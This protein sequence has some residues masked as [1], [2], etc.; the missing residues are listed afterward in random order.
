MG[1]TKTTILSAFAAVAMTAGVLAAQ[2]I[3]SDRSTYVTVS[4]PVSLPGV[5]LPAG[6][7][8]FRLAD[9][10]A[11]RNVVQVFDKDRTKIFATIIAIAA[12]RTEPSDE[13]VIT[14]KETPSDRPPAVH[15]W[16]YA[17]EKSGQEF[18]YPK[19]QAMRIAAASGESVLAMDTTSTDTEAMKSAELSRVEPGAAAQSAETSPAAQTAQ[20]PAMPNE[21][22]T[23]AQPAAPTTTQSE[24]ARPETQPSAESTPPAASATSRDTATAPMTSRQTPQATGTSGRSELPRTASQGPLVGLMGFLALAAALG[25]HAL[26]RVA[27]PRANR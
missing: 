11:S 6:T 9:T 17:G 4:G 7:Y 3:P 23:T 27:A 22:P 8:L 25:V 13:A 26:R 10:Q 24:T 21:Q 20:Q 5:T 15:Y 19:D 1:R 14:F 2:G 16:Y 12:E 18:A